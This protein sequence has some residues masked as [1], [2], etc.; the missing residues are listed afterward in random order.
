[1]SVILLFSAAARGANFK[2]KPTKAV[3]I[4]VYLQGGNGYVH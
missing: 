1:M 2:D 4:Y 3:V